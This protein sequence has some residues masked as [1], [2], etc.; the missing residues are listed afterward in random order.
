MSYLSGFCGTDAH[1][2]CPALVKNGPKAESR[3]LLCRCSCHET[4]AVLQ[5]VISTVG[6][7]PV[8]HPLAATFAE[9]S[10]FLDQ[11][12]AIMRGTEAADT[13]EA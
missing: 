6:D 10:R 1:A 2:T 12:N 8:A 3:Y 4:D 5:K 13:V 9:M 7:W 11:I